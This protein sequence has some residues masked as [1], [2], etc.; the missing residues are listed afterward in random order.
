MIPSMIKSNITNVY[1]Q[2]ITQLFH[3]VVDSQGE[4]C[5]RMSCCYTS[6][7]T[8]FILFYL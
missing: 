6:M 3:A 1:D 8:F 5:E 4:C 7:C 2:V